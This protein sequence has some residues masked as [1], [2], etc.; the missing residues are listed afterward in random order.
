MPILDRERRY[1]AER[2]QLFTELDSLYEEI[3]WGGLSS[4]RWARLHELEKILSIPGKPPTCFADHIRVET[5]LPTS[6]HSKK[7]E[8]WIITPVK[9]VGSGLMSLR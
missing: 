8:K 1:A 4:I 5:V 7:G 9:N 6:P 2:I 3:E